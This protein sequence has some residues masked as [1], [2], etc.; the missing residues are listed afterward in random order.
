L[1]TRLLHLGCGIS[2]RDRGGQCI[3]LAERG[4]VADL[5]LAA[6][7]GAIGFVVAAL[8]VQLGV[9]TEFEQYG[10]TIRSPIQPVGSATW[11][12]MSI[13][14]SSL[15]ALTSASAQVRPPHEIHGHMRILGDALT[16]RNRGRATRERATCRRRGA[17]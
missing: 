13:R 4:D 5:Q 10:P 12:R 1:G 17:Q 7:Q 2:F 8:D 3:A 14:S 15:A 11:S 16:W 6:L 9:Q